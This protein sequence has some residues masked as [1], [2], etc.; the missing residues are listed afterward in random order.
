MINSFKVSSQV[1]IYSLK[2]WIPT[3]ISF[4]SW[5]SNMFVPLWTRILCRHKKRFRKKTGRS[6]REMKK[7]LKSLPMEQHARW[8]SVEASDVWENVSQKEWEKCHDGN[9]TSQEKQHGS[10]VPREKGSWITCVWVLYNINI[11]FVLTRLMT[12][13]FWRSLLYF[14]DIRLL[15]QHWKVSWAVSIP[16]R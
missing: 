1:R 7:K 11:C 6:E 16:C 10:Y 5:E 4:R 2:K 15:H 12:K 8:R 13:Y 14:S 3:F 9:D